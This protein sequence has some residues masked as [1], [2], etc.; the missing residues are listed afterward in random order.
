V[1]GTLVEVAPDGTLVNITYFIGPDGDI[2]GRYQKKNLWHPEREHLVYGPDPHQAFDTPIGR[3]GLLLCWDLA[4]PEAFRELVADGA[5]IIIVPAFWLDVT[6]GETAAINPAS[7][8]LFL[9]SVTVARAFES[10]CAIVFVNCGGPKAGGG[11]QNLGVIGDEYVGLSQVTA[12]LVGALGKMGAEE[13]ISITEL[14]LDVLDV[15]ERAYK[16]R[17]DMKKEGWHYPPRLMTGGTQT[18]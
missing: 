4:F 3:A 15:A 6:T 8:T 1:P 12:P 7:E 2:L 11:E 17:E 5:K 13:G 16:V 18:K 10:T 9:E 14:D